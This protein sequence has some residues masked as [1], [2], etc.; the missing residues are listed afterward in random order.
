MQ[1]EDDP[2]WVAIP[3]GNWPGATCAWYSNNPGSYCGA[4]TDA[5]GVTAQVACPVACRSGCF[6]DDNDQG[7][8]F[9]EL[10]ERSP[11]AAVQVA[12]DSQQ[13]FGGLGWAVLVLRAG[14]TYDLTFDDRQPS[15]V[16]QSD[17]RALCCPG[18]SDFCDCATR[19]RLVLIGTDGNTVVATS[20][21][22][23]G[24]RYPGDPDSLGGTRN[25]PILGFV[26]PTDGRYFLAV[27]DYH[28]EGGGPVPI[29]LL[30]N[31]RPTVLCAD[32]PDGNC[33]ESYADRCVDQTD[34]MILPDN[35]HWRIPTGCHYWVNNGW[36]KSDG[37][38][39][40]ATVASID[41]HH[42]LHCTACTALHCTALH[43]TALHCTALHLHCILNLLHSLI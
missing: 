4:G 8:D 31:N 22:L 37:T 41:R 6:L 28:E 14:V 26:A 24:A 2:N 5:S 12:G 10:S 33:V 40:K 42:A 11:S 19:V 25:A 1:C 30:V 35:V 18:G 29:T 32:R 23:G 15:R 16:G 9:V 7:D 27:Y 36:C 21:A 17:V 43:C 20:T 3:T 38:V 39:G 34:W 13:A